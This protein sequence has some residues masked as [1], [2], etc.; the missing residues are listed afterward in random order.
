VVYYCNEIEELRDQPCC[1][2]VA[3]TAALKANPT[4]FQAAERAFL[5]A[6]KF[7]QENRHK[8]IEDVTAYI[9]FLMIL[10]AVY[11]RGNHSASKGITALL[12]RFFVIFLLIQLLSERDRGDPHADYALAFITGMEVLTLGI[13]VCIKKEEGLNLVV[14]IMGFGYIL[15][16]CWT[17]L[18]AKGKRL[19]A[20]FFP[21]PGAVFETALRYSRVIWV[22][23]KTSLGIVVQGYLLALILVIPLGLFLGWSLRLGKAATYIS[24]FVSFIP[25]VVYIPYGIALLPLF[26]SVSVMV[27]FLASFWPALAGTM[28]GVL[29]VEKPILDSA[30]SLNVNRVSLLS[31]S[32]LP[33]S[34]PQIR[35]G[36][37]QGLGGLFHLAIGG[38]ELRDP[39]CW[40]A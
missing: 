33:A 36:C 10:E 7:S 21:P 35:I 32:I 40:V 2:Q 6:Y 17:L 8:T 23:I 28:S 15:L 4:L 26:R 14:D 27:I 19:K 12:P 39:E 1:R 25:P 34:M 37:N 16:I 13:S 31:H 20:S 38:R 29:H 11:E 3:S 9:P 30:R 24:Q 5:K 22:N 18:T